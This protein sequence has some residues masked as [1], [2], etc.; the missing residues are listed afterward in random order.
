MTLAQPD[1]QA[2]LRLHLLGGF[3]IECSRQVAL[4]AVPEG[5]K[6]DAVL[7]LLALAPAYRLHREQVMEQLW[8]HLG[9]D[10][11]DAA[12]RKA[13]H[14]ARRALEPHLPARAHS[15][16]IETTSGCVQLVT[17]RVWVDVDQFRRA[18]EHALQS[19]E[20]AALAAALQL[21]HGELL[22]ADRYADWAAAVRDELAA[23]RSAVA[24]QLA[25][26]LEQRGAYEQALT[27]AGAVVSDDP[28]NEAA[29][30]LVMRVHLDLGQ[31]HRTI[32]QYH[33]CCAVLQREAGARPAA[34]T[35][36]LYRKALSGG[37]AEQPD[38]G[39]SERALLPTAL[40]RLP[41]QPFVG[42]QEALERLR[43]ELRAAGAGNGRFVLLAGEAGIGKTRLLREF[44]RA[45]SS[46]GALV[47]WGTCYGVD[48]QLPF[49]PLVEALDDAAR[50]GPAAA[51]AAVATRHPLLASFLPAL[52]A[53]PGLPLPNRL[54][55]MERAH[56]LATVVRYLDELGDQQPLL[57]VLDDLHLAD[58]A[59]LELLHALA[60]LAS[61]RR[62]LLVASYRD[63]EALPASALDHFATSLLQQGCCA[64]LVL[65]RLDRA[66]ADLLARALLTE[67]PADEE[68]LDR[69]FALS[70]GNPLFL[71]EC[72]GVLTSAGQ[73][74][75]HAELRWADGR[76][77]VEGVPAL[78][79]SLVELRLKRLSPPAQTVLSLAAVAGRA[80]PFVLLHR[81][82]GLAEEPLLDALDEALA[83]RLL[84][85][86]GDGF[87]VQHP[88]IRAALLARLSAPRR[89]RWHVALAS[90]LEELFGASLSERPELVEA[91]AAHWDTAGEAARAVP[92]LIAA[93][94]HAA[95]GYAAAEAAARLERALTMQA[96]TGRD[97]PADRALRRRALELLGDLAALQGESRQAQ[98][99]YAAALTLLRDQSAAGD[100]LAAA[101]LLCKGAAQALLEGETGQA[102]NLLDG[103]AAALTRCDAGP[104]RDQ[105]RVRY[106]TVLAQQRWL[107]ASFPQALAA[108]EEAARLAAQLG[109]A[110]EEARALGMVAL[111]CLPLGDW[112]RG[113][114]CERQHAGLAGSDW[115]VA[116]VA[117][118]HL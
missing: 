103:V 79:R 29:H 36:A 106:L 55:K 95:Q 57:L 43:E 25:T 45:A 102:V 38:G 49:A 94:E 117:D 15:A 96:E 35:E 48:G 76:T 59:S 39:N 109:A 61:S 115:N 26:V 44:A 93:A 97:A 75:E 4:D 32:R 66:A 11:A 87:A 10:A 86:E 33:A 42:R 28:A 60:R 72:V 107:N 53:K 92:Y 8:P 2:S 73:L 47:L 62:W 74:P 5:R 118:V 84:L 1:A 111:A 50:R 114:E 69:L 81:A 37:R 14:Y 22:P 105:E 70:L 108:A 6:G 77:A 24:L 34:E 17:D 90:A 40:Q 80:S 18:S 98:A 104:E 99:S 91:L 41:A 21:Y 82:S 31:T 100:A 113:V 64:R 19:G 46:R 110:D 12:F 116:E 30:R 83:S 68:L 9:P 51:R 85:A 65:P 16:F 52:A 71:R 78:I 3:R 101:R 20:E 67:Q 54:G 13:L 58:Q 23:R 7:K 88:L 63:E 112:A 56:L 89:R 27:Q